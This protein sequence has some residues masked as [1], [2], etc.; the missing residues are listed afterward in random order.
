MDQCDHSSGDFRCDEIFDSRELMQN[1]KSINDNTITSQAS[2]INKFKGLFVYINIIENKD[3]KHKKRDGAEAD[4]EKLAELYKAMGFQVKFYEDV[5]K[6]EFLA[7][8]KNFVI[9]Y[10]WEN[11]GIFNLCV[12]SHGFMSDDDTY[13]IC[14][15]GEIISTKSIVQSFSQC[16]SLAHKPKIF[17]FNCCRIYC[18]DPDLKIKLR[19]L[20]ENKNDNE[21]LPPFDDKNTLICHATSPGTYSYR[22]IEAGS[23]FISAIYKVFKEYLRVEDFYNFAKIMDL[24][25]IV[26]S[27]LKDKERIVNGNRLPPQVPKTEFY[28]SNDLSNPPR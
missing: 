24:M 27:K 15:D 25:N 22:N 4:V 6:D 7:L 19:R 16:L 20:R 28:G 3:N 23:Y 1:Q 9:H 5:T 11:Y 21:N 14:N 13:I 10:P 18:D 17:M 26:C 12:G 8:I 2:T